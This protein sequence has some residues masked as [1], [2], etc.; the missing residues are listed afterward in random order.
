MASKVD[1]PFYSQNT[2]IYWLKKFNSRTVDDY[3][4]CVELSGEFDDAWDAMCQHPDNR[5]RIQPLRPPPQAPQRALYGIRAVHAS[6][7]QGPAEGDLEGI[8]SEPNQAD[9][10]TRRAPEATC[11]WMLA[12]LARLLASCWN[13]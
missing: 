12:L 6:G 2:R 9:E 7:S 4:D 10:L 3:L 11:F 8:P 13:C 1:K 5:C